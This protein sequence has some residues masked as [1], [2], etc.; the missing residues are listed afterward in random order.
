MPTILLVDDEPAIRETVAEALRRP[1]RNI[2]LAENGEDALEHCAR[3]V[4][5]LVITDVVMP[6]MDGW[7]LVRSLRCSPETALVPVIFMTGLDPSADRIRG[8]RIG[9]DD[10]VAKPVDLEE[11]ELRVENVLHRAYAA[12]KNLR[13]AA[14]SGDISQIGL[15]AP[16]TMLELERLTGHLV[17]ERQ[18]D[19]GVISVKDGRVVHAE[20]TNR[21]GSAF[22]C[23]TQLLSW[24]DGHFVFKAEP[25]AAEGHGERLS[26]VLLEAA[27]RLDEGV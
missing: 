15:A 6:L 25:V 10:Y 7:S 4:P 22:D 19:R 2:E 24:S 20:L 8:F 23:V 5:D 13:S 1:Q 21:E 26:V 9:A 3:H 16:L 12:R 17:V 27:R 18:G 14:L 11:L